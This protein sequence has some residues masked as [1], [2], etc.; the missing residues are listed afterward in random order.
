MEEWMNSVRTSTMTP[1]NSKH[2]NHKEPVRNDDY[3]TEVKNILEGINCRLDK[4]DKWISKL[5][6]R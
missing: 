1:K 3:I 2:K 5:G 6:K 4:T